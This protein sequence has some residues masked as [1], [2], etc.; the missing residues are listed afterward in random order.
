MSVEPWAQTWGSGPVVL[1]EREPGP[2]PGDLPNGGAH[3]CRYCPGES[4]P[5]CCSHRPPRAMVLRA[6]A[7]PARLALRW[8]FRLWPRLVLRGAFEL[9]DDE[10][11]RVGRWLRAR[12]VDLM[13]AFFVAA[14]VGFL[15]LAVWKVLS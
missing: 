3:W 6:P 10:R 7:P 2:P 1:E 11:E 13:V 15:A 8:P 4:S 14:A 9:V 5:A 12:E